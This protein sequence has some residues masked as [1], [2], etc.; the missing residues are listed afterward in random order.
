MCRFYIIPQLM[1][2]TPGTLNRTAFRKLY[3]A[4]PLNFQNAV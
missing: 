2:L 4:Q 1:Q 3:A